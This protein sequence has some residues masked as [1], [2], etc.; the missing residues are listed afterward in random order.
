M[1]ILKNTL[2]SLAPSFALIGQVI[3]EMMDEFVNSEDGVSRIRESFESMVNQTILPA[4]KEMDLPKLIKEFTEA[5]GGLDRVATSMESLASSAEAMATI[6]HLVNGVVKIVGVTVLNLVEGF[7]LVGSLIANIA[8]HGFSM[9]AMSATVDNAFSRLGT[10]VDMFTGGLQSLKDA[11][12]KRESPSL[13][14][15]IGTMPKLLDMM[16]GAMKY[17]TNP[18][19]SMTESLSAAKERFIAWKDNFVNTWDELRASVPAKIKEIMNGIGEA[20]GFDAMGDRIA[21]GIGKWKKGFDKGIT[22]IK[23]WLGISSPSAEMEKRVGDPMVQGIVSAFGNLGPELALSAIEAL[24]VLPDWAKS[25]LSAVGI[26]I[27]A[28]KEALSAAITSNAAASSAGATSGGGQQTP[29]QITVNL[30]L[31]RKTLSTEVI[32]IVGNQAF[33]ATR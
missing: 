12:I 18:I 29:Y 3:K 10:R 23:S 16:G 25:G 8:E 20:F 21:A 4:L 1:D 9:T 11:F 5:G 15:A 31:D 13:L 7:V 27:G 24:D 19:D 6:F 14:E 26:D 17:V 28:S 22:E 2:K 30:Q 33:Q 32:D